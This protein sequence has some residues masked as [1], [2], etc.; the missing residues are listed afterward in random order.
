MD[1]KKNEELIDVLKE[2]SGTI[3]N[4]NEQLSYQV[5]MLHSCKDAADR[6]ACHLESLVYKQG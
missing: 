3:A 2:I 6:I 5:E 4:L 1:P